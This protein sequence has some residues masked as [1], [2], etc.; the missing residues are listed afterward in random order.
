MKREDFSSHPVTISA[1]QKA[2]VQAYYDTDGVRIATVDATAQQDNLWNGKS[3][4]IVQAS[5]TSATVASSA[6]LNTSTGA[7]TITIGTSNATAGTSLATD[8][9]SLSTQINTALTN[10]TLTGFTSAANTN[11]TYSAGVAAS[12]TFA[13]G[14]DNVNVITITAAIGTTTG[15]VDVNKTAT[16][17]AFTDTN[18]NGL[19]LSK[20]S[21]IDT[22]LAGAVT[23]DTVA[24]S[25]AVTNNGEVTT[26]AVTAKGILVNSQ[27]DASA[28]ITVINS[29][30]S[31]VSSERSKLGAYQ[32]RLEHT[33]NNLGTSAENLTASESRIRDVDMAKEMM[34]F[35]KNNILSQAAQAMLAQANQQPQG[36]LQL[37]R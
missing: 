30:I 33:I 4:S 37:L 23:I 11:S 36:V 26:K 20:V 13:N 34:E 6:S 21:T 29:A 8:A 18:F 14:A 3:I 35:T 2:D 5:N 22:S 17:V 25:A 28:A 9:S 27:T 24:S 31:T 19:T 10:A 16:S 7:L 15:T 32:N 12:G 1:L